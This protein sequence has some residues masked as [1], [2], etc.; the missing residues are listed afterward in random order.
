MT[1]SVNLR[2]IGVDGLYIEGYGQVDAPINP[3]KIGAYGNSKAGVI[4]RL[5]NPTPEKLE[6]LRS[7]EGHNGETRLEA[8]EGGYPYTDPYLDENGNS[9][10]SRI[11]APKEQPI[12]TYD[13][14]ETI[15]SG[16]NFVFANC[17]GAS[18]TLTEWRK[19][20]NLLASP[21]W[22]FPNNLATCS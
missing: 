6:E 12:L 1:A 4:V 10:D 14:G 15:H 11:A 19:R 18:N 21:L 5:A 22:L 3:E 13:N 20:R 8:F 9:T 17:G 16:L 2:K 7:F